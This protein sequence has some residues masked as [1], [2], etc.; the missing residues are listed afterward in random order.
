[1]AASSG[2]TSLSIS[3]LPEWGR[4]E[5]IDISPDDAGAAVI[6]VDRHFS[7]DFK[8]YLFRTTDYGA[9]WQSISG[10]LPQVYAHVVRR[11]LHNPRMYYA[12]LEN[13]L[14]VTWDDGAHWFL[15]GLGL[16][17]AAV[18]DVALNAQNNS[19][20]V[21]THGRSVWILDDL[22]P[23]QQFTPEIRKQTVQLF[24]PAEAL[25]FWPSTQVEALGD[26]AF[27]GRIL[28]TAR[29]SATISRTSRRSLANW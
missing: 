9:T 14:Y 2:R 19:L 24:P 4:I 13:G 15:F 16:P 3:G 7:G 5:S 25:R 10:D 18:Y 28:R 22:A 8:P 29:S 17:N 21:A 27:T 23:F 11:D 1:M 26:G 20:V 12:G 6:A